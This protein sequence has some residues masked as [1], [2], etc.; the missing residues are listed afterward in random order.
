[1]AK[2]SENLV[3]VL[4]AIEETLVFPGDDNIEFPAKKDW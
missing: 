1:M 3:K 2:N 4:P